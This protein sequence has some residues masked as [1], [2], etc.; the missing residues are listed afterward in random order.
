MTSKVTERALHVSL[1]MIPRL[2]QAQV[3]PWFGASSTPLH[4]MRR[5]HCRWCM[6]MC[7]WMCAVVCAAG[8]T[9]DVY[10]VLEYRLSW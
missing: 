5:Q 8:C 6:W 3:A 10:S 9:R 1:Q 2:A 4:R 7:M